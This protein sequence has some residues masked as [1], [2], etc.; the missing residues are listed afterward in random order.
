MNTPSCS[1]SDPSRRSLALTLALSLATALLV[2]AS[3]AHAQTLWQAE[4]SRSLFADKR[5]RAVGDVLNVIIAENTSSSK[6]NNTKTSKQSSIDAAINS[7]F[8]SPGASGFLTKGGQLPAVNLAGK[9]SFDG[10]GQINNSER[11]T[12][13]FAVRVI[14]TLP[15]NTLLIE[16]QRQTKISGETTDAILRGT[17]RIE[18]ITASNSIF[19]HQ[20]ADATIQYSSKGVV[21]DSQRKGW[22]LRLWDK[23][24]PF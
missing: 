8:Y 21:T 14:D 24:M 15:N 9:T 18:D 7:F 19:S 5:A 1:S 22:F 17:V 3:T 4:T 20:I 11:I 10:G 13:R 6:E 23:F 2:A 12:A 16:G